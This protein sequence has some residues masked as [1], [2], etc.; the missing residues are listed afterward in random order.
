[1]A[2]KARKDS[3]HQ[4]PA[5][6]V[7]PPPKRKESPKQKESTTD[8]D[9][10]ENAHPTGQ[11]GVTAVRATVA[12]SSAKGSQDGD[13]AA[14]AGM[15]AEVSQQA[16]MTAVTAT[17]RPTRPTTQDIASTKARSV[18][19][20]MREVLPYTQERL[21]AALRSKGLCKSGTLA[22]QEPLEI[23]E[24][25]SRKMNNFRERWNMTN[26]LHALSTTQLYEASGNVFWLDPSETKFGCHTIPEPEITW[27]QLD[28]GAALWTDA[29]FVSSS[30]N[31][32]YRRYIS[33]SSA[34]Q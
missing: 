26:C 18:H 10:L 2:P 33:H 29:A 25:I 34:W 27:A 4:S 5:P 13:I 3:P 6:D 31:E 21:L 28:E 1:M 9:N 15:T 23:S 22:D 11:A 16:G 7:R 17:A 14:L 30:E 24:D 8:M 32:Q 20:Y 12:G 19:A